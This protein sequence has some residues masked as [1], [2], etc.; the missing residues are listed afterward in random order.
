MFRFRGK[1]TGQHQGPKHRRGIQKKRRGKKISL[2]TA[3]F[4]EC[5]FG[6]LM[7]KPDVAWQGKHPETTCGRNHDRNLTQKGVG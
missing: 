2:L 5:K 4:I 7:S 6:Y 3:T 1:A